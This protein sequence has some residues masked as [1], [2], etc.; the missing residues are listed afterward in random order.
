MARTRVSQ[1]NLKSTLFTVKFSFPNFSLDV[2]RK[3]LELDHLRA[4]GVWTWHYPELALSFMLHK[5]LPFHLFPA[6]KSAAVELHVGVHQDGL[7]VQVAGRWNGILTLSLRA[8]LG[9]LHDLSETRFT[10]LVTIRAAE[11]LVSGDEVANW[12]LKER[13]Q[14]ISINFVQF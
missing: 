12:A 9:G 8:T 14:L 5:L 7:Q 6:L 10:D 1:T 4:P 13:L 3:V 2:R 11:N